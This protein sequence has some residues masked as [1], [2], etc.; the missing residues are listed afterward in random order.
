MDTIPANDSGISFDAVPFPKEHFGAD[1]QMHLGAHIRL[2]GSLIAKT[3]NELRTG[4]EAEPEAMTSLIENFADQAAKLL[5]C[6][7][8]IEAAAARLMIVGSE[9]V[10]IDLEADCA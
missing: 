8:M 9:V 4:F 7:E 5:V 2:A 3:K 6:H 1:W 10:G